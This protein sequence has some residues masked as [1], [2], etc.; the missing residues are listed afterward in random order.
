MPSTPEETA[1]RVAAVL[2]EQAPQLAPVAADLI[3]ERVGALPGELAEEADDSLL[4]GRGRWVSAEAYEDV[5]GDG[6]PAVEGLVVRTLADMLGAEPGPPAR[7]RPPALTLRMA[8]AGEPF[9]SYDYTGAVPPAGLYGDLVHQGGRQHTLLALDGEQLVGAAH[10]SFADALDEERMN[11]T[12]LRGPASVGP[13]VADCP[14]GYA[15]HVMAPHSFWVAPPARRAGVARRLGRRLAALGVPAVGEFRDPLFTAFVL[16]EFPAVPLAGTAYGR[17]YERWR[18][19]GGTGA[20]TA[21]ADLAVRPR[22]PG[23]LAGEAA[24][25]RSAMS[26]ADTEGH[27]PLKLGGVRLREVRSAWDGDVLQGTLSV[28]A[29]ERAVRGWQQLCAFLPGDGGRVPPRPGLSDAL[30]QHLRANAGE[31]L[32]DLRVRVA[33]G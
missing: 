30:A 19:D 12:E 28:T 13:L 10:W 7:A 2:L 14:D 21:E 22:H 8:Q 1:R 32:R 26:G 15:G 4:G 5:R 27:R 24:P 31:E 33:S 18:A 16:R 11:T 25:L 23:E 9:P 29:D 6:W 20:V 17:L 3:A